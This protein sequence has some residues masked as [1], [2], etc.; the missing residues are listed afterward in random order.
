MSGNRTGDIGTMLMNVGQDQ[1][2]RE[3]ESLVTQYKRHDSLDPWIYTCTVIA[4]TTGI[5]CPVAFMLEA[6][7]AVTLMLGIIFIVSMCVMIALR[8]IRNRR[9]EKSTLQARIIACAQLL[10]NAELRTL[11]MSFGKHPDSLGNIL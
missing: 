2:L 1:L 9:P 8:V 6:R 10:Q 7:D 3:L 4:A 5:Y 11:Y